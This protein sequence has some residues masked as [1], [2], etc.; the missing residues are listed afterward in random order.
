MNNRNVGQMYIVMDLGT[1]LAHIAAMKQDGIILQVNASK[2]ILKTIN[3]H[4]AQNA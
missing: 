3:G 4:I 1:Q 2:A